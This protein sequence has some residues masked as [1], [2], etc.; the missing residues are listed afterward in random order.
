MHLAIAPRLHAN[1]AVSR[2]ACHHGLRVSISRFQEPSRLGIAEKHIQYAVKEPH[3]KERIHDSITRHTENKMQEAK[4]NRSKSNSY[5]GRKQY[6]I[7]F[8]E[9]TLMHRP[10]DRSCT[11]VQSNRMNQSRTVAR[12]KTGVGMYVVTMFNSACCLGPRKGG[13]EPRSDL[14][15]VP[16]SGTGP[17]VP[18]RLHRRFPGR[19]TL[20]AR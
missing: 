4:R 1:G 2:E 20:D 5:E 9:V 3:I 8:C 19:T 6:G 16:R 13:S 15:L 12:S 17:V 18:W 14:Q 10:K 11:W 7:C